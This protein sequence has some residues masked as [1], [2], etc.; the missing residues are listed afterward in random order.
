[1]NK[2]NVSDHKNFKCHWNVKANKAM[3]LHTIHLKSQKH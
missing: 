1:M 2:F 3:D